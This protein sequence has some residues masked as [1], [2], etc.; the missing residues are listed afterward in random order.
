MNSV[1]DVLRRR[2]AVVGLGYVGLPVATAFARNGFKVLGFDID[3][4]RIAELRG[5]I[6]RNNELELAD[7][8]SAS[9]RFTDNPAE[10]AEA[11]FFIITVPTPIDAARRPDLSALLKASG[12]VGGA[13]KKGDFVVYEST[14]YPGATEEDCAHVLERASML[15]AGVDFHLGYSP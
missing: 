5:G 10:L 11:D 13:L 9:L 15:K 2:I 7:V 3:P 14:V 6:D 4:L 8:L 1:I 12:T